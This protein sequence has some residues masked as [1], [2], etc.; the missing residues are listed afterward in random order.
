MK[1]Y[2][3]AII[4]DKT[5]ILDG[6]E[7]EYVMG[8][9]CIWIPA[10]ETKLILSFHGGIARDGWAKKPDFSFNTGLPGYTA[11]S[12]W[13]SV[14]LH[15]IST[16][17][18]IL[19]KLAAQQMAPQVNDVV[20]VKNVNSKLFTSAYHC[21]SQ[22]WYGYQVKNAN[23]LKPGK[24]SFEKFKELFL[25][26]GKIIASEG[27]IGDLAKKEGNLVNGYLVDVRRSLFDMMKINHSQLLD[28][29]YVEKRSDLRDKI[30]KYGQ[31]PFQERSQNYQTYY[32]DEDWVEGTRNILHRYEVMGLPTYFDG[33]SVLDL[34]CQIGSMAL[35]AWRRGARKV[36]GLE[37][38]PEFVDCA[39]D[40]SRANGFYVNFQEMDLTNVG[41][42]TEYVKQYYP[43]G[44]DIVFAL[45]LYK[46]I[47][48]FL[49]NVLKNI[50]FKTCYVE[51][52]NTG[53]EGL[54][55]GHVQEML[56]YMYSLGTC[57]LIGQTTDRS[58]RFVWRITK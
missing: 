1:I 43:E 14:S 21:D 16:E 17:M 40:L 13:E 30:K 39:R 20:F 23:K 54:K 36:T 46:H 10:I 55:C 34:G 48:S 15:S 24:Y 5:I 41:L 47:K 33:K 9:H 26:T 58:P 42:V 35:E 52:H 50:N 18:I 2:N 6:E 12:R 29:P 11:Y 31:F 28:I 51:S 38:Q 19:L 44:V 32:L 45:S 4:K 49:F 7:F 57:E 25:D 27:A 8:K 3:N 22:G 56:K 37:Y 53:T